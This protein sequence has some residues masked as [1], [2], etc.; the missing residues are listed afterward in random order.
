MG[1][2]KDDISVLIQNNERYAYS[3]TATATAEI[4][5]DM[6]LFYISPY[7]SNIRTFLGTRRERIVSGSIL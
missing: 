2:G 3:C 7:D 1:I 6:T 5:F 4:T